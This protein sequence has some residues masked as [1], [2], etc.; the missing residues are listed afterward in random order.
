MDAQGVGWGFRVKGTEA[1]GA[2]GLEEGKVVSRSFSAYAYGRVL[3]GWH[4]PTVGSQ[5][6]GSGLR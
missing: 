5:G 1:L 2:I 4:M 6:G 3:G